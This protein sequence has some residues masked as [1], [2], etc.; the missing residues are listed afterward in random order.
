MSHMVWLIRMRHNDESLLW[1][2]L[3]YFKDISWPGLTKNSSM[4]GV[5][6]IQKR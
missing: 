2:Y 4:S 1:P 3:F 5:M 6:M